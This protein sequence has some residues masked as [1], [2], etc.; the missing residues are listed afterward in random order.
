MIR[1]VSFA[2]H[3]PAA[4]LLKLFSILPRHDL[5]SLFAHS[6]QFVKTVSNALRKLFAILYL[7][8]W[9]AAD[10]KHLHR[11]IFIFYI[12][13]EKNFFFLIILLQNRKRRSILIILLNSF[14]TYYTG[15]NDAEKTTYFT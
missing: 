1:D 6:G 7:H 9:T 8:G 12:F 5:Q 3:I 15:E 14:S 4:S 2:F 10:A 11:N 13:S